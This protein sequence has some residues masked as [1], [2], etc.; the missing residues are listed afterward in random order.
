MNWW[1]MNMT[2][3]P[4]RPDID[5]LSC[6]P[7]RKVSAPVLCQPHN[8]KAQLAQFKLRAPHRREANVLSRVLYGGG[9]L[10]AHRRRDDQRFKAL[11][12]RVARL[13]RF[14]QRQK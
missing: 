3:Y 13:E 4:D 8:L 11:R 9:G 10:P 14:Q 2:N 1:K 5:P 12:E 7:V 6:L